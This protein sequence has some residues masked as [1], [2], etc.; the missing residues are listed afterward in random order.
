MSDH[1]NLSSLLEQPHEA[2]PFFETVLVQTLAGGPACKNPR[3][4][5]RPCEL[6]W[7]H[8]WFALILGILQ[9]V[10]SYQGIRR[11]IAQG[12]LG[13]FAPV[14]LTDD[15]IISRL[16][17]AGIQPLQEMLERIS[18]VLAHLIQP[19]FP[20]D[21]ARFATE[22]FALD[23]T[24][25]DAVQRHLPALR[26]IPKGATDLL[27]GKL[28]G[29]FNIRTQQWDL[30]Q[31]RENPVGNCKLDLISLLEDLREWS[32]LLIDL[33]YFSFA[34]FDY[35]TQRHFWFITRLRQG[36]CS[37]IVHTYYDQDG[38]LDALV[39]LGSTGRNSPRT[40]HLLRLVRFG[41]GKGLRS[42]L[43]NQLNP[44]ALP[45]IDIARLYARRWDIEL[46]FLT[47]KEHLGLHQW[48][49][50]LPVLRQQQAWLVLIAAQLIHALRLLIAQDEG[51]DPFEVS[52]PLLVEYLP[53]ILHQRQHPVSW[54]LRHGHDL[55]FFRPSSRYQVKAPSIPVT[56]L[57]FP[58]PDLPLTRPALYLMYEKRPNRPPPKTPRGKLS[59]VREAPPHPR[60][61]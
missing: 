40:G 15:A 47:L 38:I 1:H 30:V 45:L 32:L 29:R 11:L 6:S 35:L 59:D 5:G 3:Y 33:G 4:P 17:R 18:R 14:T 7:P 61:N 55:G 24:T 23:E 49:S 16:K 57:H 2:V 51:C 42:Y 50:G 9:G 58:Q 28:A 36:V 19:L 12:P 10:C 43:T 26:A 56:A 27:A 53:Q 34:F 21:L 39:W 54:V 37:Q 60:R 31:W 46:A 25:W 8:L 20:A 22:I 48:W 13:P 41:D 44:I 52:L